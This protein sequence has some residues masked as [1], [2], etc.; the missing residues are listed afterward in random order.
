MN[1]DGTISVKDKTWASFSGTGDW[2]PTQ[3]VPQDQTVVG[4]RCNNDSSKFIRQLSFL[5]A[6]DEKK[7]IVG[8][9]PFPSLVTYP[10]FDQFSE[11]YLTGS[12][13]LS[14]LNYF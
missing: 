13:Q 8:E 1:E 11:L 5:L 6:S 2:S 12:F 4:F 10:D 14:G 9:I 3:R 7:T